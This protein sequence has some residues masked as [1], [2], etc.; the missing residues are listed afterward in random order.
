M[1]T[2]AAAL[3]WELWRR[4]RLR[5]MT[6]VGLV[7]GFAL[8]YPKLCALAGFDLAS[9]D[10]LDEIGKRFATLRYAGP[11]PLLI[12]QALYAMFLACGP[13]VV[14]IGTLLY[15]AWMFTFTEFDP[16]TKDPMTF[17]SRL[18]TLPVSTPF[19]FWWLF[20]GGLAAVVVLYASWIH[21]VRLPHVDIFAVYQNCFGWMTLLVLAQAIVWSLAAWPIVRMLLLSTVFFGFLGS[22]AQREIFE[23]PLVLPSLFLLGLLVARAGLQKMRHGQW[24]GWTWRWPFPVMSARA[25]L[26]GP[27]R[28]ASP[29]QAQLWFEWRRSAR[30]L[31]FITAALALVPVAI[32]LLV[33]LVGNL[34]PLEDNTIEGFAAYL[35]GLPLFIY[36]AYAVSPVRSDEPFL[37]VRPLTNGEMAMARL[38]AAAIGTVLSWLAVL[39][40][41]GAL[42]LLGNFHA[43][44]QSVSVH[45]AC[46]AALVLALMFL[47][48]RLAAIHLCFEFIGN[49]W[50]SALPTLMVL[51]VVL[52]ANA[53]SIL[54][55]EH[56]RYSYI[57][58]QLIILLFLPILLAVKFLLAFLAFRVSLKRRLLAP[59]SLVGYLVVWSLLVAAA[60]TTMVILSPHYVEFI[61]ANSMLIVLL[62]P[63][64]RIGFC[65]I[66]LSHTRHT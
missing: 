31:C 37:M 21:C 49:R 40:A 12:I 2:P 53:L 16:K 42:P 52:G 38:K 17:R 32:H 9:P 39:A 61:L 13:S 46:R 24:Q 25:G 3:T 51:A 19:L 43:V 50:A 54:E 14:M 33:R 64:A 27:K 22:P 29:A 26:L 8:V 7:L 35:A 18:Y 23:S 66:A 28:F 41:L 4:N 63:L 62:A 47:T 45:P 10:A 36:Y 58:F 34:G 11:T 56:F 55:Q 44:E 57:L 48:W 15:V 60:L 20:V 5:V 1:R 6:I 65:P 30:R 59:S